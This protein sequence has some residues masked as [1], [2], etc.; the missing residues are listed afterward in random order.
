MWML[1]SIPKNV[2]EGLEEKI[3]MKD[4]KS[5]R[6]FAVEEATLK[7]KSQCRIATAIASKVVIHAILSVHVIYI[8]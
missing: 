8:S 7:T 1:K 3:S 4:G 2:S 6:N 5:S